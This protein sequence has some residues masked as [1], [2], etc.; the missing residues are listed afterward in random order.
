MVKENQ[1]DNKDHVEVEF[2]QQQEVV[3]VASHQIR[4][5]G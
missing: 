2:N 3:L 5:T 1:A 4:N